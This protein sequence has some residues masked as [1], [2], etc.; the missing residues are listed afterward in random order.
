LS[1]QRPGILDREAVPVVGGS[2]RDTLPLPPS[3]APRPAFFPCRYID[4]R[5]DLFDASG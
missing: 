1:A 2:V 4:W 5:D 3:F